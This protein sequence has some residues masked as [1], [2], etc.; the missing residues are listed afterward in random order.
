VT[1][2]GNWGTAVVAV[3]LIA[4]SAAIW[5]LSRRL[6]VDHSNVNDTEE[7]AG[8]VT[9]AMAAVTPPPAGTVTEDLTATIPSPA[10]APATD[11]AAP[12]AATV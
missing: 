9:T 4:S 12:P 8:V 3:F 1:D 11:P 5:K 10:T 6:V 2:L 7:P